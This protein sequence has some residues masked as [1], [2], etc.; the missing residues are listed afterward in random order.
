MKCLVV[1]IVLTIF[2]FGGFAQ[3]EIDPSAVIIVRDKWGVPHIF[4]KTD[5]Q[6]AYGL[7]WAHAEDN[8]ETIQK[9]VLA[10]KSML[11]QLIGREGATVDYVIHLLRIRDLVDARYEQDI[12][13][14]FKAVL[15]GYCEGLNAYARL[16]PKEV[17]IKRAFPVHPKDIITY[18]VLQLALG[19]G[20]ETE[21]KKIFH[22][23]VSMAEWEP[24]GS[25]AFAFNSLKTKD[26]SAFLAINT[27]HPLEGQVAW[28]EAHLS[29]QEGWNIIGGLFPGSP[30]IFTGVNDNIAWTHTVNHPDK[31]DVY[32]LQINPDNHLQY[33][34][35]GEWFTLDE[36][37]VKLKIK[38]PG[39]NLQ[40]KRK[41]YHSIYGPTLITEKGTFSIRTPALMDIRGLEE[42]FRINKARNFTEFKKALKMEAIPGYNVVYADRFDTI[43]YLSNARMPYRDPAYDWKKTLPGN[44]SRT[45][46]KQFHPIE[47][48]PQL[49]NPASGYLYNTNNSPFYATADG[50]NIRSENYDRTM[51]YETHNNNRSNRVMELMKKFDRIGFDEF[52]EIKYDLQLPQK[53]AYPVN[54]DTLFL[55][56]ED[57]DPEIGD[58]IKTLN[59]WDRKGTIDSKGA[60]VFAIAFYF[61]AGKYQRDENFK[62]VPR[63]ICIHALRYAKEYLIR[64]FGTTDITLGDYQRL[65]RG[66]KSLPLPG[67][68]DVLGAMYSTPSENGRVKGTIGECYIGLIRFTADGPEIETVNAFGAS[69][70]RSSPHYDDQME[71][72]QKQETKKMTLNIEDIFRN[73]K[74][75]YHPEILYK[76]PLTAKLNRGRR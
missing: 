71:L 33:M 43:F 55:L 58:L 62:V 48:L 44:T 60:A 24:L 35:D 59:S 75:V 10:S 39:F 72:F 53:L 34:V 9:T 21:L 22:G 23:T 47:D 46:W 17:L 11:G 8:F 49:V 76:M 16:H 28:Y 61:I 45:L 63:E 14:D 67:L 7:A 36:R 66:N 15:Q 74:T 70:R 27:H 38:L 51:G 1:A 5:A 50:S 69:N 6:V 25:N 29:S 56:R 65:E 31:I 40:V 37:I 68:P 57:E 54:M 12:S 42:W 20:V 2:A 13:G 64:H 73:A 19:C 26:G 32:Q 18:S 52:R 3:N 4:G 30:V 41:T